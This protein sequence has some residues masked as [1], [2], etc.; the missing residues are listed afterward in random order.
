MKAIRLSRARVWR[1]VT[2]VA[3]LPSSTR[4]QR[5][6]HT[7]LQEQGEGQV[8]HDG[9]CVDRVK[10]SHGDVQTFLWTGHSRVVSCSCPHHQLDDTEVIDAGHP[11][12][13]ARG[14]VKAEPTRY[15]RRRRCVD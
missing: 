6:S 13:G 15:G 10:L 8:S 9:R 14:V 7:V 4:G 2:D 12:E 11:H 5:G 1:C 3:R